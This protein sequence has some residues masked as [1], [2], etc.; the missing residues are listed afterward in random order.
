MTNKIGL[1]CWAFGGRAYGPLDDKVAAE[2][3][4][5]A[6]NRGVRFFDT[7][8]LYAG[9][10]SEEILG[11]TIGHLP[12]ACICTKLGYEVVDG[13][14]VKNYNTEFLDQSLALS[15]QR[16]RRSYVEDAEI[17]LNAGAQVIEAR[18][19]LLRRDILDKYTGAE[20]F[21]KTDQRSSWSRERFAAYRELAEGLKPLIEKCDGR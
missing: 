14:A 7:A 1:G 19:S 16:L 18:Y 13:K 9:G 20:T 5:E 11:E 12:D 10:R 17:S 15:L 2:I 6:Y 8:H 21:P 3:A 4:Q